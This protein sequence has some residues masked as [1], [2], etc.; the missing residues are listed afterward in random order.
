MEDDLIYNNFKNNKILNN[1]S[2]QKGEKSVHWKLY[3]I[4]E[5]NWR[6]QK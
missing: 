4:D 3:D 1:I 6:R 2:N 5:R